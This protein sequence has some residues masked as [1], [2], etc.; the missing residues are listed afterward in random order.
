MPKPRNST[1]AGNMDKP[2][3]SKALAGLVL[4]VGLAGCEGY[5]YKLNERTVFT[6]PALFADY[7]IA[8]AALQACVQ[9]AIEDGRVTRAEM[10]EDLNCSDA[11]IRDLSGIETF[12]ALR[13][14]GLD[15]NP[16][17]NLE[18]LASLR[19]L[20]LLY[21]RDCG[22][23]SVSDTL[24]AAGAKQVALAGNRDFTCADLERLS[25][26][27]IEPLDLPAHCAGASP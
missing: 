27:G 6:P 26:C 12:T 20:E 4:T 9:Q 19:M 14:L 2:L 8:D 16:L 11:G 21:L 23:A 7:V 25:A 1:S 18:P 5:T 22:L 10:L 3:V 13:R 24:C 15:G 17:G